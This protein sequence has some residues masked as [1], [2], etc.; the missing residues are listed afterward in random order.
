MLQYWIWKL[1][2]NVMLAFVGKSNRYFKCI[3]FHI[4][5]WNFYSIVVPSTPGQSYTKFHQHH[6]VSGQQV[7]PEL[8]Q[9]KPHSC[10]SLLIFLQ[11]FC[12]Y[13]QQYIPVTK[14]CESTGG[15]YFI[16]SLFF[17]QS[18]MTSAVA[19]ENL[20]FKLGLIS[21]MEAWA[22]RRL[23]HFLPYFLGFVCSPICAIPNPVRCLCF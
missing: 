20:N 2:G 21:S 7:I 3:L 12:C 9:R 1:M 22:C 23:L 14:A 5:L 13:L 17:Y 19:S 10:K 18:A 16:A 11:L 6:Q 15:F 4:T 8:V